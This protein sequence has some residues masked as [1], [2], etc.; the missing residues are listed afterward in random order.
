MYILS[1]SKTYIYSIILYKEF[2]TKWINNTGLQ[3]L[4][5]G[6]E[7]FPI[8][9]VHLNLQAKMSYHVRFMRKV[10]LKLLKNAFLIIF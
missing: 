10:R 2:R 8:V 3:N 1:L 7:K 5:S 4:R 6:K 9:F